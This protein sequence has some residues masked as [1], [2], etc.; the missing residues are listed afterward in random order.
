MDELPELPTYVF[1]PNVGGLLSLV[2]T[3]L[4]PLL[5]AIVTTRITSANVKAILLL[6][7][8]VVKTFIEAL[9]SAEQQHIDFDAVPFL[10]N[11]VLNFII[12]VVM[13][14]G[15]WKPTGVST[16]IQENVGVTRASRY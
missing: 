14:F 1:S 15:L 11:L 16:T 7:L 5:V 10:M 8:V 13:H 12:A 9:I 4:L 3:M 6:A 2:L